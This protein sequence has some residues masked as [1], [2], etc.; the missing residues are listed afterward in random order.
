[1]LIQ[2]NSFSNVM[3]E[4][5]SVSSSPILNNKTYS[6]KY[7]IPTNKQ[8]KMIQLYNFQSKVKYFNRIAHI[9]KCVTFKFNNCFID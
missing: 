7:P 9:H 3:P 4:T 2:Y 1:M 8:F 5:D 6:E